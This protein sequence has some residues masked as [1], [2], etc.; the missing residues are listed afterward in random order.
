MVK[1]I[2]EIG[3]DQN[4]VALRADLDIEFIDGEIKDDTRLQTVIPTIKY[5]LNNG[6][7][8]VIVLGH[9]GRPGGEPSE[10]LSFQSLLPYFNERLDEQMHFVPYESLDKF[11]RGELFDSQIKLI[12]VENLRF[13]KEER[14]N[15]ENFAR[16]IA[17]MADVYVNEAFS[18]SHRKHTSIAALPQFVKSQG[19]KLAV[20]LHFK[21]EMIQL[22]KAREDPDRPVIVVMGGAKEDKIV[23]VEKFKKF[24]DKI[25]VG[26]RLPLFMPEN[27]DDS[28]L[29]VAKL[30]PDKCDITINSANIFAD[31]IAKAGTIILN[32]PMG[33][34]EEEG[35]MLGTKKVFEAV[36]NTDA[37]KVG[38]GGDTEHV[39][40]MLELKDKMD[41]VSVGG[42]ASLDFLADGS[43][44]GIEV[45]QQ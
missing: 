33:K 34:F 43:L 36:A 40:E 11:S 10:E 30:N 29:L 22:S 7:Y 15:D 20:G 18:N 19:G 37:Y 24:A 9:R 1:S 21:Q 27:I 2:D 3:L 44:S 31:E 45:L 38:G 35:Q 32:G 28:K 8:K 16:K 13:W 39:L 25:L 17:P 12:L 23:Y 4:I 14:D 41:W 5:L 6:A 26:G 42:G